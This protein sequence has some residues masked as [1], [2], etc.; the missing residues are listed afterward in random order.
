MVSI[1]INGLEGSLKTD[2]D[3]NQIVFKNRFSLEKL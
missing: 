3:G 1:G 2:R